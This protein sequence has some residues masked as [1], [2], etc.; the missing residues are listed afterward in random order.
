METIQITCK[1]CN[2]THTV[3][4][5]EEIPVEATSMGC[6]WCPDC[7]DE[8]EENYNEWYYLATEK[9]VV[10]VNLENQLELSFNE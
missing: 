10:E 7:E 9:E 1:G 2:T 4:R 8:P 6:N 5:T 3:E